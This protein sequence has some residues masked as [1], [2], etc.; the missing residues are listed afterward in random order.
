MVSSFFDGD[1][2]ANEPTPWGPLRVGTNERTRKREREKGVGKHERERGIQCDKVG[3]FLVT[4]SP[5]KL[6]ILTFWA[7]LKNIP[8]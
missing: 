2:D 3:R 6:P 1:I 7:T 4:H 8:F 5:L